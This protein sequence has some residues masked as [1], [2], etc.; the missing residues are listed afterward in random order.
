MVVSQ[1]SK[2]T[3]AQ[4]WGPHVSLNLLTFGA[5]TS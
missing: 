4:P 3:R 5:P 1:L 2:I